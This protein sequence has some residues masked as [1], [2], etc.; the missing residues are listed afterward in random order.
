[1]G[2]CTECGAQLG[3]G[4]FC[5]SCGAR[6]RSVTASGPPNPVNLALQQ[7]NH[8]GPAQVAGPT[9][10]PRRGGPGWLAWLALG[11]V[12][13]MFVGGGLLLLFTGTGSSPD[14]ALTSGASQTPTP[15][16]AVTVTEEPDPAPTVTETEEKAQSED[17][18][19]T[20]GERKDCGE[21]VYA[22]GT[23]SC[24]FALAVAEAFRYS[25]GSRYLTDVY[26]PVTGQY[27]D[28]S[29]TGL[30]PVTCV[31]GRARVSIY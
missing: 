24:P 19:P 1:M 30:A 3:K 2:F 4:D 29:C 13:L 6:Q 5:V 23:A 28:L 16:P 9:P 27:Y 18:G 15:T 7:F 26:S 22:S 11:V 10:P 14:E 21:S 12:G 20:Q 17:P 25:G 31:V 8:Q